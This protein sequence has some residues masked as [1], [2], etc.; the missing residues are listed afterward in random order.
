MNCKNQDFF[1][2]EKK[3]ARKY[4]WY[5]ISFVIVAVFFIG[6]T[7]LIFPSADFALKKQWDYIIVWSISLGSCLLGLG[8]SSVHSWL[9]DY[10]PR[11][12]AEQSKLYRRAVRLDKEASIVLLIVFVF[13]VGSSIVFFKAA[14]FVVDDFQSI[15]G[16]IV[17]SL[18]IDE[19]CRSETNSSRQDFDIKLKE[20][21]DKAEEAVLLQMAKEAKAEDIKYLLI[22][23]MLSIRLGDI[24]FASFITYMFIRIYRYKLRLSAFYLSRADALSI[25]GVSSMSTIA[26]ELLPVVLDPSFDFGKDQPSLAQPVVDMLQAVFSKRGGAEKKSE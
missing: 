14:D 23:S 7:L 11:A 10:Y 16:A 4:A 8:L 25:G 5:I 21:K 24:A 15:A 1:D 18:Q 26:P 19:Q 12:E 20:C 13:V 22:T 3:I 17:P 9:D 2:T 6:L